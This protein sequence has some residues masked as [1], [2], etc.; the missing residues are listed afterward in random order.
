VRRSIRTGLAALDRAAGGLALDL[1]LYLASVVF[2][3]LTAA[4]STLA[5]HRG[6]GTIAAAGYACAATITLVG[7]I[8]QRRP[9]RPEPSAREAATVPATKQATGLAAPATRLCLTAGAWVA[10]ALVPLVVEAVRRSAGGLGNAQE[11][12]LT[13]EAGGHRLI[14]SGSPYLGRAAIA[15]LPQSDRLLAY[16]PYQPGM[17]IF[18]LP[19]AYDPGGAWW[20]DARVGFA[21][22]TAAALG[23]AT[24]LLWRGGADR[25]RLVRGVQ[26]A[27]VLPI[28][29]LTLATGGD[30]LPVLALCLL[31][32][33]L[34]GR[35]RIGGAGLALGAAGALKLFAWPVALVFGAYAAT[36]GAVALWRYAAAAVGLPVLTLLP[37]ALHDPGGVVEN[38]IR[39]PFGHG[40]VTSPAASPLP[41]HLIAAYAPGGHTIATGLLAACGVVVA[42]LLVRRPPGTPAA[43]CA[44][45]GW[46]LLAAMLLLPATRFGYLLY[47][48]ALLV[49]AACLPPTS[50]SSSWSGSGSRTPEAGAVPTTAT[51]TPS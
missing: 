50:S 44:I 38:V 47:P 3:L 37:V 48:V 34:A 14:E 29:A 42:V 26:A 20:S 45:S 24:A 8:L 25:S 7:L 10:T 18:G 1:A 46:G 5:A 35:G 21:L 27:T 23:W 4:S 9:V 22:V 40:L 17:A 12:V 49:W 2:A 11:E 16:L 51:G 31:G 36:K 41:G 13:I 39:F 33:A 6:W 32:V 30:D 19:R 28:C 15:A 43:A